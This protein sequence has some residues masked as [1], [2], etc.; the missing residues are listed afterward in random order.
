MLQSEMRKPSIPLRRFSKPPEFRSR[1]YK[2][3]LHYVWHHGSTYAGHPG[4]F[5]YALEVHYKYT[6]HTRGW[7]KTY[8]VPCCS[9]FPYMFTSCE[10]K[11]GTNCSKPTVGLKILKPLHVH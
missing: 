10:K 9:Q 11:L 5:F 2:Y 8:G 7:Y 1:R 6:R 4:D 3:C